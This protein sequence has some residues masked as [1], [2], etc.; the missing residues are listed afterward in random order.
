MSAASGCARVGLS[1]AFPC[2]HRLLSA[3]L[4]ALREN[5]G[6]CNHQERGLEVILLRLLA[7]LVCV[8]VWLLVIP[9]VALIPEREPNVISIRTTECFS[10]STRL[11]NTA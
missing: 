6:M 9:L 10:P 5:Q 4:P 3:P 2:C 8:P 11:S 1:C 7:V